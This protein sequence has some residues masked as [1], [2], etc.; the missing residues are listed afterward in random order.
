MGT[1][2]IAYAVSC[3]AAE[4]PHLR[5]ALWLQGCSLRC[6]GCCNPELFERGRG[7]ARDTSALGGDV[8]AAARELG[9]EGITVLGGE[10]LEQA[11]AL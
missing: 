11:D 7:H 8:I 1:I 4:G 5:F 6:P 2:E 3:T 10:P 9:I